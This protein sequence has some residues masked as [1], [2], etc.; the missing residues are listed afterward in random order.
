MKDADIVIN[1]W[2]LVRSTWVYRNEDDEREI[3][4]GPFIILRL[5]QSSLDLLQAASLLDDECD[6]EHGKH[7]VPDC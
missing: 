2:K 5:F 4:G 1:T 6:G 3:R 7:G